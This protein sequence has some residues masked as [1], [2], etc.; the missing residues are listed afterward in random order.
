MTD[1]LDID[2]L[3]WEHR[4]YT[5]ADGLEWCAMDRHPHPCPVLRLCDEVERLRAWATWHL[6]SEGFYANEIAEM[7]G[8]SEAPT[9]SDGGKG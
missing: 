7:L 5:S 1:R 9:V 2:A 4:A 6:A 3:R 8:Q